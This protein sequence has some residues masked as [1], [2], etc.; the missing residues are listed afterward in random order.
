MNFPFTVYFLV[1]LFRFMCAL[2]NEFTLHS[3]FPGWYISDSRVDYI[4]I[5]P[6]TFDFLVGL[7]SI[8]VCVHIKLTHRWA[9]WQILEGLL[10]LPENRECA[11]CK[12][13][14]VLGCISNVAK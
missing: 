1:G 9:F 14:Y 12:A 4:M 6:F 8:N 5:F 2:Y 11:D 3:L 10:K 13:K 7:F